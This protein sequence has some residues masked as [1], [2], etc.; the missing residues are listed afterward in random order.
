M[1]IKI[2][3][4]DDE[5]R[6]E[7]LIRQLFRRQIRKEELTFLF[8]SD[9]EDALAKLEANPDVDVLL[10]DINM[11]RMDGLTLLAKIQT[12]K[13]QINPAIVPVVISAYSDI[14]NIRQ[15]MKVG[16][17]DFVTKP[18][19]LQDLK[20]TVEHTIDHA[21]MLKQIIEDKRKAEAA[22]QVLNQT[23]ELRVEER[24]RALLSA[25][26]ALRKSNEELDA[27]ARTVAH[28]LKNPISLILG[29]VDV[30]TNFSN[31]MSRAEIFE[32]L[33]DVETHASRMSRIV[34][35]LLMLARVRKGDVETV[36]VNT[37]EIVEQVLNSRLKEMIISSNAK[38]IK[39]TEWPLVRGHS[40]WV[41]EVWFNYLS[42][43][44]KYGGVPPCLELGAEVEAGGMVRFWVQD[45]GRGIADDVRS[46]LF[47]EFVRLDNIGQE[48]HGLGL[49]IVQRIVEKLGGSVGVDSSTERGSC[50][51]FTLPQA[52][53]LGN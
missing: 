10:T 22:I 21:Q 7:S 41:E 43:G 36:I 53:P 38:I 5:P 39:P 11:P 42:N 16:G 4:V 31:D 18:V 14:T 47:T 9:G 3:V 51:F 27:F 6:L 46:R 44:L 29:Y 35:G 25:N 34:E 15:A 19:D 2:L 8:A 32:I 24:T 28:D 40:G 1:S 33:R 30:L 17:F 52:Q 20:S 45:N 48:G 37:G 49:S 13:P 23:L 12:I 26:E 50:F